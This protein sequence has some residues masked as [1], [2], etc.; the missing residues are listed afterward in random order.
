MS[1]IQHYF[2][3]RFQITY[4]NEKTWDPFVYVLIGWVDSESQTLVNLS[5]KSPGK[6]PIL[7]E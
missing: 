1:G 3:K 4:A 7:M 2:E 6:D 5:S